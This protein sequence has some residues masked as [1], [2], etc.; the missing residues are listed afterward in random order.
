MTLRES[1]HELNNEKMLC[2]L[3]LNVLQQVKEGEASQ[4]TIDS[5]LEIATKQGR[6]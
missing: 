3:L 6:I 4:T 5:I 2:N 1:L